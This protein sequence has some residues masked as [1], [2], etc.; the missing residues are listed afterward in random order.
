MQHGH[1]VSPN[2]ESLRVEFLLNPK[3]DNQHHQHFQLVDLKGMHQYLHSVFFFFFFFFSG[4]APAKDP[5][6]ITMSTKR[7]PPVGED[8][9]I[10]CGCR[11]SCGQ[12]NELSSCF[13]NQ[14][15]SAVLSLE[16][17]LLFSKQAITNHTFQS[18]IQDLAENFRSSKEKPFCCFRTMNQTMI[19][20]LKHCEKK[21][22]NDKERYQRHLEEADEPVVVVIA[23]LKKIS[24]KKAFCLQKVFGTVLLREKW[25][26]FPDMKKHRLFLENLY[27]RNEKFYE[28]IKRANSKCFKK[29]RKALRHGNSDHDVNLCALNELL[30]DCVRVEILK[31]LGPVEWEGERRGVASQPTK[32]S[33]RAN[34][35]RWITE[36]V[37][38]ASYQTALV[39]KSYRCPPIFI[40]ALRNEKCKPIERYFKK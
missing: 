10:F 11:V 13:L 33:F 35:N 26:G 18:A 19:N 7:P 1:I 24:F 36:T 14:V 12:H 23:H 21:D 5:P 20:T 38:G 17:S 34:K 32:V 25:T 6:S 28:N 22:D 9:A 27:S 2:P 40:S 29:L 4:T 8:S 31:A 39:E 30:Y 3:D 15:I 37:D 16:N